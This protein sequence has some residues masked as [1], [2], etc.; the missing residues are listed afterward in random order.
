MNLGPQVAIPALLAVALF[1]TACSGPG[2]D[3]GSPAPDPSP[4]G[5]P[6][7]NSVLSITVS[8]GNG[9]TTTWRLTCDPAGGDHPGPAAACQAL[10]QAAGTALPAVPSDV[11]CAEVFGGPETATITGTWQGQPVNSQLARNNSCETARWEALAA[12]LQP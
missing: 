7:P 12:V 9:A 6:T 8:D 11:A 5:T 4:A 2:P 3:A 1:L 10:E